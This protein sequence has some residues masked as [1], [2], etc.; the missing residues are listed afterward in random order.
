MQAAGVVE[1]TIIP[2]MQSFELDFLGIYATYES[3]IPQIIVL[4]TIIV[5]SS[6]YVKKNKKILAELKKK[7]GKE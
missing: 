4:I 2:W 7:E 1:K 6:L 3:L 5:F